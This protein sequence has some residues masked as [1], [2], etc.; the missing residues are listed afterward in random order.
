MEEIL[1]INGELPEESIESDPAI[2][3]GLLTLDVKK[4]WIAKGS[5]CEDRGSN[6]K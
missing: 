6:T 3:E 1:I 4:L 2:Q 5:F